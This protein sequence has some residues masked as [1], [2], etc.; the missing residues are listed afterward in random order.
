MKTA[1][2]E[3]PEAPV[4]RPVPIKRFTESGIFNRYRL[5]DFHDGNDL[6]SRMVSATG[7]SFSATA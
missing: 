2:K 1:L 7:T 3:K 4:K 5:D 6:R